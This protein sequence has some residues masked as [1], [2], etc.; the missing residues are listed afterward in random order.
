MSA[1]AVR[2]GAAHAYHIYVALLDPARLTVDRDQVFAALRAEG[3]GVNVHYRP[4]HLHSFYRESFGT[5]DGLCPAAEDAA[6]RMLTLPLFPAMSDEDLGDV[7]R[8]L[9]KVLE[10]Y[11]R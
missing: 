9:A 3:I 5:G 6:A 11:G 10:A 7:V 4:V 8:A 2:P 1:P